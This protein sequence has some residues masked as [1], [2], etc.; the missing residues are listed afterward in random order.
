MFADGV[1]PTKSFGASA[2]SGMIWMSISVLLTKAMLFLMQ[3]VL[4]FIL[5]A[6]DYSVFAIVSVALTFVVGLQNS[7]AAKVLVQRQ[8]QYGS[9]VKDYTDF[10]LY[11][12]LIGACV[13]VGLGFVFG[14]FYR[15]NQLVY[16]IALSALAVPTTSLISIQV[17]R[18]SIDLRFR[19][20][21]YIDFTVALVQ[22]A[23]VI[24]SALLGAH[25]YSIAIGLVASTLLRYALNRRIMP[26][27]SASFG[28]PWARFTSILGN[29]KWLIATAFL[30]GLSQQGD[31]F[32]LGRV[33]KPELLGYYYFGFQLTA[34][35]GQLLAQGIGSTL[36]PIFTAMKHD[37][38]ALSRAFLR[39]GSVINF[40]C[41]ILC[42]GVIGF[43][44]WAMHFIWRGKWD[45]AIVTT[46]AIATTLPIRM[47]S[48]LGAVTIDS[49]ARWKLRTGLLILDACT[50]MAAALIGAHIAGLTGASIAVA[51]QRLLGGLIDFSCAVRVI[52]GRASDIVKFVAKA[53]LP[54]FV[55]A[56][57]L[58]FVNYS[59]P[60]MS[61]DLH[62]MGLTALRTLVALAAYGAIAY[63]FD[64]QVI[65]EVAALVRRTL[66]R[67]SAG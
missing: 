11:M 28:L 13:L 41:G 20:M 35:V 67:R 27:V 58:I 18:L 51:S 60:S 1:K 62:D 50:M 14:Q 25:Y 56:A 42:L 36:F 32:V 7:G 22:V 47:L 23:V 65:A 55:P 34:N 15:N 37:A 21:C 24:G 43:A 5:D 49:F 38:K 6:R 59:Q 9:L 46:V 40:A 39:S 26:T 48:P 61:P 16:V 44:P 2:T 66:L 30:S 53:F 31:Y 52:G 54:F 10:S 19:E 8:E 17:S 45:M 57:A 12:G 33:F 29:V 63:A 3:F 4:G 64:R